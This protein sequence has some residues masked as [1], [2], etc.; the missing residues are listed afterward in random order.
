MEIPA[1][2][3][4]ETA[5]AVAHL[6]Q[7]NESIFGA[8]DQPHIEAISLW[9][10]LPE[11]EPV[12]CLVETTQASSATTTA[13]ATPLTYSQAT[14]SNITHGTADPNR[15]VSNEYYSNEAP[16]Q[17][18]YNFNNE[19]D[20]AMPAVGSVYA[21]QMRGE[22]RT[23]KR[24]QRVRAA[25]E[26]PIR[27]NHAVR[28]EVVSSELRHKSLGEFEAKLVMRRDAD[29]SIP[30]HIKERVLIASY[31][32]CLDE[33]SRFNQSSMAMP[34]WLD[35]GDGTFNVTEYMEWV[36]NTYPTNAELDEY[37]NS[38]CKSGEYNLPLEYAKKSYSSI[39]LIRT[40]R[41]NRHALDPFVYAWL[42]STKG[43]TI[44]RC[45]NLKH[46]PCQV[47][48]E[49]SKAAM[50]VYSNQLSSALEQYAQGEQGKAKL[51]ER[52]K[53]RLSLP[54]RCQLE[55]NYERYRQLEA[56]I[57]AISGDEVT[58]IASDDDVNFYINMLD[59]NDKKHAEQQKSRKE[60][61]KLGINTDANASMTALGQA[62]AGSTSG[63]LS[64]DES[65]LEEGLSDVDSARSTHDFHTVKVEKDTEQW[66]S[67]EHSAGDSAWPLTQPAAMMH[68]NAVAATGATTPVPSTSGIREHTASSSGQSP[69]D[70]AKQKKKHKL[71]TEPQTPFG[72]PENK[73]ITSVKQAA[74]K[75]R[76]E[77][78]L[79]S[80]TPGQRRSPRTSVP[81][82]FSSPP[83]LI[84]VTP[85]EPIT[86]LTSTKAMPSDAATSSTQAT[87]VTAALSTPL[88]LSNV[89][90]SQ[91]ASPIV[92]S[93]GSAAAACSTVTQT[94]TTMSVS[95]KPEGDPQILASLRYYTEAYGE[96]V[97]KMVQE[98]IGHI[99]QILGSVASLERNK[100]A[101]ITIIPD[102]PVEGVP[103]FKCVVT[104]RDDAQRSLLDVQAVADHVKK[105]ITVTL[106]GA[107][108]R[109]HTVKIKDVND[110]IEE[111]TDIRNVIARRWLQLP[112]DEAE[113][114]G[115][116]DRQTPTT[117][118]KPAKPTSSKSSTKSAAPPKTTK[119]PTRRGAKRKSAEPSSSD[120]DDRPMETRTNGAKSRKK[121]KLAET[122]RSQ[123]VVAPITVLSA[124]EAMSIASSTQ[125]LVVLEQMNEATA[126]V[127]TQATPVTTIAQATPVAVVSTSSS[128]VPA[129]LMSTTSST[130]LTTSA[131]P[132]ALPTTAI[133][134]CRSAPP[135][136][137]TVASGITQNTVSVADAV[138]RAG[139]STTITPVHQTRPVARPPA[140]VASS[141]ATRT[142][143]SP[144]HSMSQTVPVT[145]PLVV[146]TPN[147]TFTLATA[148]TTMHSTCCVT[149]TVSS[150]VAT[151]SSIAD[152]TPQVKTP[153]TAPRHSKTAASTTQ[154]ISAPI[155]SAVAPPKSGTVSRS[156]HKTSKQARPVGKT[157]TTELTPTPASSS[158]T[159]TRQKSW[160]TDS[161]IVITLSSD[162]EKSRESTSRDEI[163]T[164]PVTQIKQE[165]GVSETLNNENTDDGNASCET[166]T[167]ATGPAPNN[168]SRAASDTETG[169]E[170][171]DMS[172]SEVS[173]IPDGG[174]SDDSL[175]DD[176]SSEIAKEGVEEARHKAP[177]HADADDERDTDGDSVTHS[178]HADSYVSETEDEA[179]DGVT[180]PT[181][182]ADL[183][184]FIE[185][186][187][188]IQQVQIDLIN[189][190]V[191][192]RL[193]T[194]RNEIKDA[195]TLLCTIAAEAVR[196][197]KKTSPSKP[198]ATPP[199]L[200]A[201]L[202]QLIPA[203]TSALHTPTSSVRTSHTSV[204]SPTKD[205]MVVTGVSEIT[206]DVVAPPLPT[207]GLPSPSTSEQATHGAARAATITM[208]RHALR[209]NMATG[210]MRQPRNTTNF[211]GAKVTIRQQ[212]S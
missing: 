39:T 180:T 154:S 4:D 132:L 51:L 100:S 207:S 55:L 143:T 26:P 190:L 197:A 20:V 83:K 191:Q 107:G 138:L 84:P 155:S 92:I 114:D 134:S 193:D 118:I 127:A 23:Y 192:G 124:A 200:A 102:E 77:E 98:A 72:S 15:L 33:Y 113:D 31:E 75:A 166:L 70:Q 94:A 122:E 130:T 212:H 157:T 170:Q 103:A 82:L 95:L 178:N 151:T 173:E 135:L 38:M 9:R 28:Q 144:S 140:P 163:V 137:S 17:D 16:P 5:L 204:K 198:V 89:E 115:P 19:P 194:S 210:M 145:M 182:T 167:K 22:V 186:L 2:V 30:K 120:D 27:A 74:D 176:S 174:T 88:T 168:A 159:T 108:F 148:T 59:L 14:A 64:H 142:V 99:N 125:P 12:P 189:D 126:I 61:K 162:E 7:D 49:M 35:R 1:V 73:H 104:L 111:L 147:D 211:A 50:T 47:C 158:M 110:V 42:L 139:L 209:R 172:V 36:D 146:T 141:T 117:S 181:R 161:D 58:N 121:M 156:A 48:K 183:E 150:A 25:K 160:P 80:V 188:K 90:S 165:P 45:D 187:E 136:Y 91:L 184:C 175:F 185:R 133:T 196:T 29:G 119:K 171:S 177:A 69:K 71:Y 206:I 24:I 86:A 106:E 131:A 78:K 10:A 32:A 68:G 52:M 6:I 37:L 123:G 8:G 105:S 11:L 101:T 76:R 97:S 44:L 13:V 169:D 179:G 202:Y 67:P 43:K 65:N 46:P 199:A 116:A 66:Q 18:P 109:Q 56:R 208:L 3:D 93:P 149:T 34:D 203:E 164:E 21:K 205:V 195:M 63:A 79:K 81:S 128:I 87:P 112:S 201:R 85:T 54:T 40:S 53:Q 96:E 62:P 129:A 153:V 57:R 41:G 60:L 152:P